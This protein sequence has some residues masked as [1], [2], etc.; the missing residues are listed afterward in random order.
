MRFVEPALAEMETAEMATP[1][2]VASNWRISNCTAAVNVATSCAK[3][4]PTVTVTMPGAVHRNLPRACWVRA[5]EREVRRVGS[6]NGERATAGGAAFGDDGGQGSE[7]GEE[8]ASRVGPRDAHVFTT[9]IE[10]RAAD[11][12]IIFIVEWEAG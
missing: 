7:V 5:G 9:R 11:L 8:G 4:N 12:A 1:S 3:T 6:E 10:V 2:N